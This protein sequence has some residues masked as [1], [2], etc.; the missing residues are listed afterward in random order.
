MP[1]KNYKKRI[2]SRSSADVPRPS[3]SAQGRS[4]VYSHLSGLED[5][6]FNDFIKDDFI[7]EDD[8]QVASG[9]ASLP[10][11]VALETQEQ[12][13]ESEQNER[14]VL[15][16][17]VDYK[18]D[19]GMSVENVPASVN[20]K[21]LKGPFIAYKF[22]TGAVGVVKSGKEEE[23]CWPVCSNAVKYRP[24]THAWPKN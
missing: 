11:P 6:V 1:W 20:I 18:C 13:L 21:T 24:G 3:R 5:V 22:S 23:S 7:Q 9:A 17:L 15:E 14:D 2:Q 4:N 19:A 12:R 10:D 8:G 16:E